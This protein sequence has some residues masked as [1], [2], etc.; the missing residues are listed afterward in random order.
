MKKFLALLCLGLVVPMVSAQE[1]NEVEQL[2][3]QM[4]EMQQ[5]FEK[6]R[7]EDRQLIRSLS[8][9][10]DALLKVAA[11]QATM[12]RLQTNAAEDAEKAK[13]AAELAGEL[14]PVT[15]Q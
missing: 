12:A 8:E 11:P 3:R 15:N 13:L 5:N 14:G 10:V 9:K 1:T 4:L 6:E 7:N 2:K